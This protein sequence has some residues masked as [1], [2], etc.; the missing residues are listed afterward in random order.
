VEEQ[1]IIDHVND[2]VWTSDEHRRE[3]NHQYLQVAKC[4]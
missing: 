3:L 2:I 1:V 4:S